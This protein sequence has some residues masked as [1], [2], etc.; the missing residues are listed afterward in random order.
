MPPEVLQLRRI[1]LKITVSNSTPRSQPKV[2]NSHV[3]IGTFSR[4]AARR[5]PDRV[6]V[7]RR[8]KGPDHHR[9]GCAADGMIALDMQ[10]RT[11]RGRGLAIRS[12]GRLLQIPGN[13]PQATVV[14]TPP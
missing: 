13:G 1:P 3:G 6:S 14:L 7:L 4:C 11:R 2:H 8:Q 12:N 9:A 5:H 10:L